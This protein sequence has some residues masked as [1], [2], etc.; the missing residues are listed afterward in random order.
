MN[1]SLSNDQINELDND[2]NIDHDEGEDDVDQWN[3][4]RKCKEKNGTTNR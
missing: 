2:R 1:N 4:P 3:E